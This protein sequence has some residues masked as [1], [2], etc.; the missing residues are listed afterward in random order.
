MSTGSSS[1]GHCSWVWHKPFPAAVSRAGLPPWQSCWGKVLLGF[2]ISTVK[3]VLWTGAG[4]WKVDSGSSKNK[5]S[6]R[7]KFHLGQERAS[8]CP[9]GNVKSCK[10]H[11]RWKSECVEGSTWQGWAGPCPW[12]QAGTA[13][14]HG[15]YGAVQNWARIRVGLLLTLTVDGLAACRRAVWG[16]CTRVT[17]RVSKRKSAW[18]GNVW[19]CWEQSPNDQ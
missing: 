15:S 10:Y 18:E 14:G 6:R 11:G 12:E 13:H 1:D 16:V 7:A 19:G 9:R 2:V 4:S 5:I 8:A 3:N 17:N